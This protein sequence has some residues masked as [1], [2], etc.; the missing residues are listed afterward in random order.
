MHF[1]KMSMV[2]G[3][4]ALGMFTDTAPAGGKSKGQ[5]NS[6]SLIMSVVQAEGA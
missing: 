2:G 6:S 1:L 4:S 3:Q 5:M